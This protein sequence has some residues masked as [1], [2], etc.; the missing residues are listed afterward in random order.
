MIWKYKGKELKEPPPN[1]YGFVYLIID[2]SGKKYWGKKAFTH[3]RKVRLSKKRRKETRKRV[4]V[5]IKD[6]GWK[7][8][9]GSCKP[10]QEYILQRG[11][12][13]GF[14]GEILKMCKDRTS[15]SYWETYYLFKEHAILSDSWNS[16]VLRFFKGKVHR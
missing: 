12:T 7:N 6:S 16:H 3:K 1:T 11:G 15:L 4:E 9:S 13:H 5:L 10:L 2:D 8:Y 14:K